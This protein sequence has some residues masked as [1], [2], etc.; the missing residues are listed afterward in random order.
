MSLSIITVTLNSAAYIRRAMESVLAQSDDELQYVIIDGLSRDDTVA[1]VESYRP[2]LGDRL[3][4]VSEPDTGLYE[5]M[6]KGIALATGEVI[7][8]LNSDDEYLPGAFEAVRAEFTRGDFD[9]VYGDAMIIEDASQRRMTADISRL[10]FYMSLP[11]PAC[12]VRRRA[13]QRWGVFDIGYRIAA[14]YDFVLRCMRAGAR[15]SRVNRTLALFRAGGASSRSFVLA[16]EMYQVHF[17]NLGRLHAAHR[18]L[19]R[20]TLTLAF[21][22]RR[23][24]GVSLLGERGYDRMRARWRRR[25]TLK[26]Y[27]AT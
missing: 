14:D 8:I 12:F 3:L 2:I 10:P 21:E 17:R 27:D 7:G 25:R 26:A 18:F 4:I 22:A 6:N 20:L 16:R 13:Y 19:V 11:H 23:R 24:I 5:A 9:I 1:I 15:F